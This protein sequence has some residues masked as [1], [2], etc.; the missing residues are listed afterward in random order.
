[1][2]WGT[3]EFPKNFGSDVIGGE[4][5]YAI[6]FLA[7]EYTN[8]QSIRE[9]AGKGDFADI[10]LPMPRDINIRNSIVY[11]SG[12][13]ETTGGLFDMTTGGWGEWF[14][15]LG[16]SISWFKDVTGI[17]AYIGYRPMDERDSIFKGADFRAH[18][19]N[20]ILIPKDAKEGQEVQNIA[21]A[22]QTLAYPMKSGRETY[23]RVIH[24]P[25]WHISVFDMTTGKSNAY[26][27]SMDPLPSVL[28]SVDIQT[29][30]AAGGGVYAAQGGFPAA[31]KISV[32]FQELEPAINTG[33]YLQSR[34]QLRGRADRGGD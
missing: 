8:K 21:E 29:S 7:D 30:G 24:P 16:G 10:T 28:K 34:S 23:S 11:T 32:S 18:N 20:W 12:Q 3:L 27:W 26:K 4:I 15:T 17:S 33:R 19:Y 1:M 25:I 31:T 5:P 6:N 2:A 9:N 14:K 13:S 22:F